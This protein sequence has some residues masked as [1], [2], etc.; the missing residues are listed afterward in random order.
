MPRDSVCHIR[1]DLT[2]GYDCDI[3]E[4]EEAI[5][6]LVRGNT[7]LEPFLDALPTIIEAD[8]SNVEVVSL[9][10]SSPEA[11]IPFG[12]TAIREH[13]AADPDR[14]AALGEV[15]DHVLLL[16][17]SVCLGHDEGIWEDVGHL[18]DVIAEQAVQ[19]QRQ[20]P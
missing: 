3:E 15:E 2:I 11:S 5:R 19:Y 13:F 18:Y 14:S 7:V 6:G 16:A 20:V 9:Y 1:L 17:A 8:I 4:I 10:D 12:P